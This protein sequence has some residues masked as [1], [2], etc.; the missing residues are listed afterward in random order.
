MDKDIKY[1]IEN[2]VNFNPVDYEDDTDII[3]NQETTSALGYKNRPKTLE[4][5]KELVVKRIKENPEK[6]YLLDID[7]SLIDDMSGLFMNGTFTDKT[8]EN[9]GNKYFYSWSVNTYKLKTLDLSTWDTSNV[10]DMSFMFRDCYNLETVILSNFD[11]SEVKD[12]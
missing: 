11:T 7:T 5:L 10:T 2:I 6:P 1:L 3:G 9:R 8:G 12:M 4:E